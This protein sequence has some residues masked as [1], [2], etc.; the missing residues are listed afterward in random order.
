ML[1]FVCT[2]DNEDVVAIHLNEDGLSLHH[3]L[4][5]IREA[6]SQRKWG[7][8]SDSKDFLDVTKSGGTGILAGHS[9]LPGHSQ[10]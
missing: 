8:A 7:K 3:T 6:I 4:L 5:S 9:R 1:S 10:T 2:V